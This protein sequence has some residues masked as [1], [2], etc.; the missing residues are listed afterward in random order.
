MI[1][2]KRENLGFVYWNHGVNL[3]TPNNYIKNIAF[4]AF[5]RMSNAILLYSENEVQYIAET[6]RSKTFVA[7]NTLN[8]DSFPRIDE[9]AERIK[10][11]MGIPYSKVVLFVGR[12]QKRKRIDD[13]LSAARY[14]D[15]DIGVVVVGGKLKAGQ[16]KKVDGTHNIMYLGEIYDG[17][18][19][20]RIFKKT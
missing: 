19:I 13:L 2:L 20:N 4:R 1:W 6:H 16:L 8:F 15:E 7:N 17:T 3:Q 12:M 5:H 10:T 18:Q 11:E 14:L 9:S